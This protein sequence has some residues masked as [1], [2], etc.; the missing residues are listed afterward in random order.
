MPPGATGNYPDEGG[1]YRTYTNCVFINKTVIVPTYAETYDTTAFRNITSELLVIALLELTANS[2]I[3]AL[4]PYIVSPKKWL[5]P[6]PLLITHQLLHDTNNTIDDYMANDGS[7]IA[8]ELIMPPYII[9][10]DTTAAWQTAPM[11]L[12][13]PFPHHRAPPF[14]HSRWRPRCIIIF[15][16]NQIRKQTGAAHYGTGRL[17]AFQG[18]RRTFRCAAIGAYRGTVKYIP[19][20]FLTMFLSIQS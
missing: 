8:R 7:C 13:I 14:L 11:E 1:S 12:T 4:E 17:L 5:L 19:C 10:T 2:I 3:N 18:Y 15:M 20:R 9:P 6:D 16:L